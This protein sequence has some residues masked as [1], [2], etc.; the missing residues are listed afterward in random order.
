MISKAKLKYFQSLSQKKM[1]GQEGLFLIEGWRTLEE[2][3]AGVAAFEALVYTK[4]A[5]L[6]E[7]NSGIL[8]SAKKKSKDIFEVSAREFSSI[9]DTVHAQG[10]AALVKTFEFDFEQEVSR[11]ARHGSAFVV[12]LDQ[13]AEPGNLGAII[14]TADW[15]GTDAIV[16]SENCVE[17][18]NPKVVRA[19]V[20]SIFHLPIIE[21]NKLAGT[22]ESLKKSGF[23]LYGAELNGSKEIQSIH[24]AKKSAVVIGN[25]ARGIRPEI[26]SLLDEH[27]II[28]RFGKAESLNAGIA[29]GIIFAH[30]RFQA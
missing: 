26:S 14:R 29:A 19:T 23:T 18:Y 15:F 28:P 1:R 21:T 30:H 25:E 20:G 22:I 27:I 8:S 5:E 13:I 12:A 24:W 3:S 7:E 4:N 2:A 16:L 11:I 10:I 9:S 6:R 17:L